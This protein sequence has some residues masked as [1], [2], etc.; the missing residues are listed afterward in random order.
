MLKLILIL[1]FPVAFAQSIEVFRTE[2]QPVYCHSEN[3]NRRGT[4][5]LPE[6][7][8]GIS[9]RSS[10]QAVHMKV[11]KSSF[12][13]LPSWEMGLKLRLRLQLVS[14]VTNEEGS[15][16]WYFEQPDPTDFME[17]HVPTGLF[18]G[19]FYKADFKRVLYVD[20]DNNEQVYH[21]FLNVPASKLFSKR[22]LR[23]YQSGEEAKA[24]INVSYAYKKM[25]SNVRPAFRFNDGRYPVTFSIEATIQG[26]K[27]LK[28]STRKN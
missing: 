20:T 25:L 24:L 9:D 3:Q 5:E 28:L 22:E 2:G 4:R 26:D 8:S 16:R 6:V 11:I 10:V 13:P 27:L 14:C 23:R 19:D 15:P 1:I 18:S 17:A 7:F 12:E 21:A